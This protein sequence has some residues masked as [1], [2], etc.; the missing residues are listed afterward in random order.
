[1]KERT[2]RFLQLLSFAGLAVA[3]FGAAPESPPLPPSSPEGAELVWM[4]VEVEDP[5][6]TLT[7]PQDWN[8]EFPSVSGFTDVTILL[9]SSASP[10][11]TSPTYL[12]PRAT[13]NWV[14]PQAL[15]TA[16]HTL[17]VDGSG[18]DHCTAAGHRVGLSATL[19]LDGA[20]V[21]AT[22]E[23]HPRYLT[24]ASADLALCKT[25]SSAP[26]KAATLSL[27]PIAEG[28]PVEAV[29]FGRASSGTAALSLAFSELLGTK[30][31]Q[32]QAPW[33]RVLVPGSGSSGAVLGA[34]AVWTGSDSGGPVFATV[35]GKRV[36]VGVASGNPDCDPSPAV[37]RKRSV[38]AVLGENETATWVRDWEG[39]QANICGLSAS[40]PICV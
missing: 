23:L 2:S 35:K 12:T 16:A 14:G 25:V 8:A 39:R 17:C 31:C 3:A 37:A 19:S 21:K 34:G 5:D 36:V 30:E 18:V 28:T 26:R 38:A 32:P 9:A 11:T 15:L 29:G 10:P 4:R 24:A 27:D 7:K 20:L 22:C 13:A 1:M 6:R 40:S 33:A